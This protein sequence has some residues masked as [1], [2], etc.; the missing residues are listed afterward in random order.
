[1][2]ISFYD[3]LCVL[4]RFLCT[5]PVQ[6]EKIQTYSVRFCI[7]MM[8]YL[9]IWNLL[10]C[11]ESMGLPLWWNANY[12]VFQG[13]V[14]L[15]EMFAFF[16][17]LFFFLFFIWVDMYLHGSCEYI[18]QQHVIQVL[19]AKRHKGWGIMI[20]WCHAETRHF[21]GIII[22]QLSLST[23]AVAVSL[24]NAIRCFNTSLLQFCLQSCKFMLA[25]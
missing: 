11:H 10:I 22:S 14:P 19:V 23:F 3:S 12:V 8:K 6:S 21:W 25:S 4:M 9:V 20:S 2:T 15:G 17:F 24:L 13:Y 7:P 5:V 18:F 1:M 16:I